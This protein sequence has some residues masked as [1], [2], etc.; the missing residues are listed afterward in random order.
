MRHP[1]SLDA[2]CIGHAAWDLVFTLDG[3]LAEDQKY[4]ARDLIQSGGGPAA[5]AA[6]LL[7]R[8]GLAVALV[9]RAGNDA[10]GVAMLRELEEAGVDTTH[11]CLSPEARTPLSCVLVSRASGARTLVNYRAEPRAADPAE[12]PECPVRA[13]LCDGHEPALSAL[14]LDRFPHALS[15]LDGGSFREATHELALRVDHAVVSA[16]FAAAATGIEPDTPEST[17]RCLVAL[18]LAYPSR[19]AITLG[20]RGAAAVDDGGLPVILAPPRVQAVDSS[21]A[22]DIFH[23]AFVWALLSGRSYL[24]AL[25]VAMRAAALSVTRPGGRSSL[26]ERELALDFAPE[27]WPE[28]VGV[29]ARGR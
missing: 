17:L 8:W 11:F 24:P 3:T 22:G 10:F 2:L 23:G 20:A 13:I 27:W 26:P 28:E 21:A 5:N 18:A 25:R 19:I 12:L 16:S 1:P 4:R 14:A 15:V 7:S 6:C 9:G 29:E